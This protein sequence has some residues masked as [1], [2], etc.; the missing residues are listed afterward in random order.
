MTHPVLIDPVAI[1][2]ESQTSDS[3]TI[4]AYLRKHLG[5]RSTAYLA[6]LKDDKMI[7]RWLEG[8]DPRPLARLRLQHAYVAA[9]M[10]GEAFGDRTLEA[11]FYGSNSRLDDEAPAW[12]LRHAQSLDDLR[13]VVPAAKA[14]ARATD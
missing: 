9:R 11:W 6:G 7:A 2:R 8:A 14:F 12:V 5:Q 13:M 4:V 1:E 10:I 3:A